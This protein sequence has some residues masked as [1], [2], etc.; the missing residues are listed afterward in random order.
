MSDLEIRR[1]EP[2]DCEAVR[3]LNERAMATTPEWV[4]DAPDRDLQ[5][6]PGHYLEPG[7]EFLVGVLDGDVLATAAYEPLA[8]WMAE[9]FPPQG[10]DGETQCGESTVELSRM[11]VNPD[12]WGRGFGTRIYAEL[13]RRARSDGHRTFVLNTGVENERAREFYEARGFDH[14]RDEHVSIEAVRMHLSLYRKSLV[15]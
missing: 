14:V 9:Q 6:V 13:E 10:Q 5:D 15:E 8:G 11:R 7:G 1:F 3:D 12:H 4:P 2:A